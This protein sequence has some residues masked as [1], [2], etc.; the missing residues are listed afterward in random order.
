MISIL[1]FILAILA[2]SFL[3]FIHELGHYLMAKKV[4]MRVETFSIGFGQAI[5]SWMKDGT[6]WQIG[7]LPFGGYV[8]IAGTDTDV[9]K[10]PYSVSDGFFGKGPW[11]RIKVAFM[12][13]LVNI[14]FALLLFGLLYVGGGRE[15][16]FSEY[17]KKIGWIDPKS[18]V[19]EKGIRPGDEIAAYN[20]IPYESVKDHLNQP[21]VGPEITEVTGYR[22]NYATGNKTPFN[23]KVK[24]YP[25]PMLLDKGIVTAGIL[26]PAMNLIY[27]KLPSGAENPLPEG[28]PLIN[29]G[30]QYGDRVVW[31]DGHLIFSVPQLTSL[32]NDDRVLLT[33]E[34]G[35]RTLLARVPRVPVQE[36]R[37][38]SEFKEELVD[39]QY[40]ADLKNIK[41]SNLFVL[42]YNLTNEGVVENPLK[43]IEKEKEQEAFPQITDSHLEAPL[44]IRDKIVAIDG[45]PVKFSYQILQMLQ[46]RTVNIIVERSTGSVEIPDWFDADGEFDASLNAKDLDKIINSVG[47]D[48]T[49]KTSG[50]YHLLNPVHPKMRAE[51]VLTPEKDA[52][53]KMDLTEK[54]RQA[55][56]IED[57]EK[58]EAAL[59]LIDSKQK[60]YVIGMPMIADKKVEYNP[61]PLSMFGVVANE[62]TRTLGSL[63]SGT[64]NPKWLSGPVGIVQVVHDQAMLSF[65]EMIFWVGAISLNLGIL[66]LLPIPMLDGGTIVLSLFE[67]I[68]GRKIK[69]KHLE[70]LILPF[71]ILLILFFVFVTYHDLERIFGGF[72]K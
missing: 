66:N 40:E 34:R 15:K 22:V 71:A 33:I 4:G 58:R 13:P 62:I 70:R 35:D 48:K 37:M 17:T 45:V 29:S 25:H 30:I 1:F 11:A 36:F 5:T 44:Q 43:F 56:S 9:D 14:V 6:K 12:G 61:G 7:W 68:T 16:N 52:L 59:K 27:N 28:S 8:K 2:L 31:M 63:F 38:D 54:R 20:S 46:E 50:K 23:I 72:F 18:E 3:I 42:P 69:P 24:N 51:F 41:T 60:E 21:L 49:L 65:N 19:Y 47:T 57:I 53:I 55:E 10:D 64:L 26:T 32:L 39:W 67:L